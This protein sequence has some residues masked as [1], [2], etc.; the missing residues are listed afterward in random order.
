MLGHERRELAEQLLVAS[1][2][3]VGLDARPETREAQLVQARDLRPR[4][5]LVA[6]LVQRRS[7]PERHRRMQRVAGGRRVPA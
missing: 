3:E 5:G 4:E 7:A 2:G 6:Q 1:Q